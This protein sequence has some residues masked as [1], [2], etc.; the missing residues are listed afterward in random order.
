MGRTRVYDTRLRVPITVD[1]ER[2]LRREATATGLSLNEVVRRALKAYL[3]PK[4]RGR[5]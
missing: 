3:D 2:A 4:K 5:S 1:L